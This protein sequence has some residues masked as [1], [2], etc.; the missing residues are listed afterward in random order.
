MIKNVNP[1]VIVLIHI[2]NS[3]SENETMSLALLDEIQQR[4]ALAAR[5]LDTSTKENKHGNVVQ[6]VSNKGSGCG[7]HK[8]GSS[9]ISSKEQKKQRVTNE[10]LWFIFESENRPA[11]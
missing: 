1:K 9:R 5:S 11:S 3:G 7:W 2:P 8:K 6:K 10:F 4:T